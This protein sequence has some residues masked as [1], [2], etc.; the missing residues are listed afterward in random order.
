M[1]PKFCH[2]QGFCKKNSYKKQLRIVFLIWSHTP[3]K[4]IF[5][6]S[7]CRINHIIGMI[8]FTLIDMQKC[9]KIICLIR[10]K[11]HFYL[12]IHTNWLIGTFKLVCPACS[13]YLAHKQGSYF[14]KYWHRRWISIESCN[15]FNSHHWNKV[16]PMKY[17]HVYVSMDSCD[18]FYRYFSAIFC[19]HDCPRNS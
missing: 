19:W 14:F 10:I 12:P 3:F 15:H 18:P 16:Y 13:I 11:F 7:K 17:T 9:L 8:F 4:Y 5:F 6:T 2:H 1:F